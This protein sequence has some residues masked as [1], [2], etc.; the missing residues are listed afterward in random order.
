[1]SKPRTYALILAGGHSSRMGADK[2]T[3]P[4]GGRTLLE[5]AADFWRGFGGLDGILIAVGSESHLLPLPD[6]CRPVYDLYPNCGP[7]AGLHAAFRQTDAEL[8]YISAV[9]MPFLTPEAVL[10]APDGDAAVYTRKGRPEPLF[11]VYRRSCLP[12]L[13]ENLRMGEYRMTVL[14][15]ALR[16]TCHEL[17]DSLATTLSNWNSRADILLSLAGTPPTIV[18]MG[19]SGSGKTTFLE[20]L[21]PELTARG[22]R[23]AVIKHDAHSFQMDKP[24]KDTWRFAQAGAVCTAISGPNGWAM[25]GSDDR[26]LDDLREM[27]PPVDLILVEGHKNSRYPKIQVHRRENQKPLIPADATHFAL[28]TDEPAE[29]GLP[30]FGLDDTAACADYILELFFSER[31]NLP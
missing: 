20:K 9:D 26:T 12:L 25:L 14:L 24:G 29:N 31:K 8:L 13:E 4:F 3:L 19:W 23:T 11:G 27:L 18:F 21:L 15:D 17:P 10:P 2:T 30:Q 1:M 28:V 22:L 7:A 5:R 6:G 16:T